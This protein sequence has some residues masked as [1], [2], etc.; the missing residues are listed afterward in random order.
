MGYPRLI[1]DTKKIFNNVKTLVKMSNRNGIDIAGVTKGFCANTDI[2]SS[3]VKGGV[4]YLAD[5]RISNLKK[6]KAFDLPK[7]LLRLPMI[8][9]AEDVVKYSDISLNSEVDTIKSI[10]KAAIKLNKEHEIIF[11]VDLGD[12][13]E[14]YINEDDLY[15]AIEKTKD[16][17]GI[18]IL[19]LGVNFTCYGGVIPNKR[20]VEKLVNISK[21]IEDRFNLKLQIISGGNSS[22]IYMLNNKDDIK[23]ITNLRLGEA[24][25][26][27][28]ESAYGRR[29][30]GTYNDAFTLEVEIIEIKE[31]PS[32]PTEEIGR[33]AFGKVPMFIDRGIRKRILCAIGKQDVDFDTIYPFD[34]D[35]IVL[36]GSSDHLILDGS[37]SKIDYK[38]GDIIS[39]N[40]HYVSILRLM[41]S[42][43]IEKVII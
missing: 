13:R 29:I 22:S 42:E 10:S 38:I 11:M 40:I 21:E 15:E 39:F 31:K 23:G 7:M 32:V 9:E 1:V 16:L 24:L 34:K 20:L 28:T 36:G 33:D 26:C 6:L 18:V 43:Y 14:G 41:T 30:E 3:Y 12:L 19:G 35:L 27:G 4:K 25:I 17:K 5:S 8:S 37:D 2:V